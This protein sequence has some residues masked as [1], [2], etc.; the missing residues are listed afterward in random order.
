MMK[1]RTHHVSSLLL[2]IFLYGQVNVAV[3]FVVVEHDYCPEHATATRHDHESNDPAH[4]DDG[5]SEKEDCQ[6]MALLSHASANR[7]PET[8]IVLNGDIYVAAALIDADLIHVDQT[9]LFFLAPS[10]SPPTL[11]S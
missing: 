5:H 6:V 11:L 8:A 9:E 2:A 3:H 4:K 10:N 1:R 7:A